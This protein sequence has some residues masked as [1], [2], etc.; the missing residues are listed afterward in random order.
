MVGKENPSLARGRDLASGGNQWEPKK[1][2]R[3]GVL[4]FIEVIWED[5]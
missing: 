3:T 1:K 2:P 4:G 5:V